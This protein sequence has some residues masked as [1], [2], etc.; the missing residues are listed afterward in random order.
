MSIASIVFRLSF[1]VY[2]I[3]YHNGASVNYPDTS[4]QRSQIKFRYLNLGHFLEHLFL[5]VFATVAAQQ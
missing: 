4:M 5:P 1:V 3:F 2:C